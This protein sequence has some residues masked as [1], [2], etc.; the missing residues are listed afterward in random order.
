MRPSSFGTARV[1]NRKLPQEPFRKKDPDVPGALVTGLEQATP[2]LLTGDFKGAAIGGIM[3]LIK[4][5]N[6]PDSRKKAA[7]ARMKKNY[8]T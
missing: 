5:L 4:G 3:G 7:L 2:S 6:K 1:I 8:E